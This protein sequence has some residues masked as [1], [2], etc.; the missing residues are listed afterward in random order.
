MDP[1][2][3]LID[4]VA[5]FWQTFQTALAMGLSALASIL[6]ERFPFTPLLVALLDLT[7]YY[8]YLVVI[9]HWFPLWALAWAFQAWL[10]TEI[11]L[12][13]WWIYR[14]VRLALI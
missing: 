6:P 13:G 10:F 1:L 9:G 12:L 3:L 4:L 14:I 11:V 7:P 8:S 5:W 2:Q